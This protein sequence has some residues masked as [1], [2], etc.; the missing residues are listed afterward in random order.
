MC[1]VVRGAHII[2]ICGHNNIITVT[3]TAIKARGRFLF[4]GPVG[5]M[6]AIRFYHGNICCRDDVLVMEHGMR[7]RWC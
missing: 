2:I 4:F 1:I 6:W 3:V 5:P 7:V